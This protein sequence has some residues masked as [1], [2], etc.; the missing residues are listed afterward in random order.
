MCLLAVLGSQGIVVKCAAAIFF[1][2]V[3]IMDCFCLPSMLVGFKY[4]FNCGAGVEFVVVGLCVYQ[5]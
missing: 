1:R 5:S 4:Q 3:W 2:M